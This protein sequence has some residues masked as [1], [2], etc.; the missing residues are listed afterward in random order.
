MANQASLNPEEILKQ[1]NEDLVKCHEINNQW[2]EEVKISRE[3][4]LNE[5]LET[6]LHQYVDINMYSY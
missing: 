2:N 1:F 4:R 6:G 5:E 3:K